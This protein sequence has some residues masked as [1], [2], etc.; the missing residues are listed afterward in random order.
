MVVQQLFFFFHGIFAAKN[1][2]RDQLR[3]SALFLYILR[4]C[5]PRTYIIRNDDIDQGKFSI[6]VKH[7]YSVSFSTAFLG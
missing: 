2:L 7:M 3:E 5:D 1:Q 6:N 4:P